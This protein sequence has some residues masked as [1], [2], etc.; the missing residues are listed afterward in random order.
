MNKKN[1]P[2]FLLPIHFALLTCLALFDVC[3]AVDVLT[4]CVLLI[5][6]CI[7]ICICVG[8]VIWL[9]TLPASWRQPRA[10]FGTEVRKLLR[11][12]RWHSLRHD[13][14]MIN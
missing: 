3:V 8:T 2:P 11:L 12:H 9:L 7:A 6:Y 5:E 4:G 1:L 10:G 14:V 13:W